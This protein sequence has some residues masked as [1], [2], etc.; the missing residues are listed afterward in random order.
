MVRLRRFASPHHLSLP[1]PPSV[2]TGPHGVG[3]LSYGGPRPD[4]SVCPIDRVAE[5][6]SDTIPTVLKLAAPGTV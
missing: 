2:P 4:I 5:F 3:A 6:K 1:S